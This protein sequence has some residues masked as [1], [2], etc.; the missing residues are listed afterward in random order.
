MDSL[1]RELLE[2]ILFFNV[3]MCRCKK[4]A[5]LPL[6]LVCKDFDAFLKP[7]ALRALQ[8]EFSKFLR[9]APTPKLAALE[10]AGKVCQAVYIDVMVI[11]DEG[12]FTSLV[13]ICVCFLSG[14]GRRTLYLAWYC[15]TNPAHRRDLPPP[16]CLRWPCP[17]GT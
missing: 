6:R 9:D 12:M 14:R 1:P 3:R 10:T 7:Y 2:S 13:I 16:Q 17:G 15:N 5:L 8:L 11:R 4:N